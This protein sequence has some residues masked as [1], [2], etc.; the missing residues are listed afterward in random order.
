M[1]QIQSK[2]R[3][4]P[5]FGKREEGV[6]EGSGGCLSNHLQGLKVNDNVASSGDGRMTVLPNQ[7]SRPHGLFVSFPQKRNGIVFSSRLNY[8][9]SGDN[10]QSE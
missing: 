5:A 9:H 4:Y 7:K 6:P 2:T 10:I 1:S 3:I 8:L